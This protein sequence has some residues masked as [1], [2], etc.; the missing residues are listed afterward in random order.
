[1]LSFG[2]GAFLRFDVRALSFYEG[3]AVL[4]CFLDFLGDGFL[5]EKSDFAEALLNSLEVEDT[6]LPSS[7]S[8]SSSVIS[9]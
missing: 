4:L 7:S 3:M 2:T 9:S 1:M 5:R 8:T 6:E